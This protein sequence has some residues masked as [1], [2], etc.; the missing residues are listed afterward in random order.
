MRSEFDTMLLRDNAVPIH[1][2]NFQLLMTEIYKTKWELNPSFMK[3]NFI[4][5]HIPYGLR[6][7]D[8]LQLP[9][10]RT[11][12]NGLDTISYHGCG[13]WQA[14]PND[15]KQSSCLYIF[16]SR[17]KIRKGEECKCRLGR[18]FVAQGGLYS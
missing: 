13:L 1:I 7:C 11:T 15:V 12:C 17:S 4:E 8:N 5:K 14:L 3:E 9:Q 18:P 6:G 16:K 2:R 10:A